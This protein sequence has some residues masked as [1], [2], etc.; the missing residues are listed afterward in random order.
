LY[1]V[2]MGNKIKDLTGIYYD[3]PQTSY[4]KYDYMHDDVN[5][6]R[7]LPYYEGRTNVGSNIHKQIDVEV[8]QKSLQLNRP[9]VEATTNYRAD[10]TIDNL[11]RSYNLKPTI[12]IGGF[13]S[14]PSIP[15]SNRENILQDFDTDKSR[16]RQRIYEMQ[17]DRNFSMG[18]VPYTVQ[19]NPV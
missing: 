19:E 4:A 2:D 6:E 12:N 13:E 3:T 18:N 8:K 15:T 7:R 11:N 9:V 1:N 16:M 5:L 14:V 17:Q 10:R